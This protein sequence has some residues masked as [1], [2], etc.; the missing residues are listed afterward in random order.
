MMRSIIP[1]P[2]NSINTVVI[3]ELW[4]WPLLALT[5]QTLGKMFHNFKNQIPHPVY[6]ILILASGAKST[7]FVRGGEMSHFSQLAGLHHLHQSDSSR[8]WML[9]IPFHMGHDRLLKANVHNF[10]LHQCILNVSSLPG[11]C[12]SFCIYIIYIYYVSLI[13]VILLMRPTEA[14]SNK[15]SL[16]SV[17]TP[18]CV[19]MS[20]CVYVCVSVLNCIFILRK[21]FSD[22]DRKPWLQRFN[23][24][25]NAIFMW[26]KSF[27][28][29]KTEATLAKLRLIGQT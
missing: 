28:S 23:Q 22:I 11:R 4:F 26:R 21:S 16:W 14:S 17:M 25:S 24:Q 27:S 1:N 6:H 2:R 13:H 18:V 29:I 9:T 3:N 20:V 5:L 10:A 15:F 8:H 12:D 19:C 7:C